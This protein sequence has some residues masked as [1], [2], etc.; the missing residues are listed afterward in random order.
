MNKKIKL[1]SVI[2]SLVLISGINIKSFSAMDTTLYCK[3]GEG[4]PYGIDLSGPVKNLKDTINKKIDVLKE[5]KKRNI[6]AVQRFNQTI[7]DTAD[8]ANGWQSFL[9][10]AMEEGAKSAA[11]SLDKFDS[12]E[13][14][15]NIAGLN[16]FTKMKEK[17]QKKMDE[18]KKKLM[19][20]MYSKMD[21][22]NS[23]IDEA[24]SGLDD[25]V[26][27]ANK[28]LTGLQG[29]LDSNQLDVSGLDKDGSSIEFPSFGMK[30][31]RPPVDLCNL[32]LSLKDLFQL[33]KVKKQ[34]LVSLAKEDDQ[35]KQKRINFLASIY[36]DQ[37]GEVANSYNKAKANE[38]TVTHS[39]GSTSDNYI[40]N[41]NGIHLGNTNSGSNNNS[42]DTNITVSAINTSNSDTSTN[43]SD[44][45]T[46]N[47]NDSNDSNS[48]DKQFLTGS[49]SE[50]DA[51]LSGVCD[52]L[53]DLMNKKAEMEQALKDLMKQTM[54]NVLMQALTQ[55]TSLDALVEAQK[56][57]QC[58]V[59][60]SV[61][62][63]SDMDALSK[64]GKATEECFSKTEDTSLKIGTE[65]GGGAKMAS[66]PL[67]FI[68][69]PIPFAQM[70]MTANT[71]TNALSEIGTTLA[72]A[73]SCL[74]EGYGVGWSSAYKSCM[75]STGNTNNALADFKFDLNFKFLDNF[76]DF[77]KM[78]C[79]MD[80]KMG[81]DF[82]ILGNLKEIADDNINTYKDMYKDVKKMGVKYQEKEKEKF[83]TVNSSFEK[84]VVFYN[85]YLKHKWGN[86]GNDY[87]TTSLHSQI[88]KKMYGKD[89][90][91]DFINFVLINDSDSI[92][93][94]IKNN[95]AQKDLIK[96]IDFNEFDNIYLINTLDI[97]AS[98]LNSFKLSKENKD[99]DTVKWEY[100]KDLMNEC[101][102]YIENIKNKNTLELFQNDNESTFFDSQL[103]QKDLYITNLK[104]EQKTDKIS[105]TVYKELLKFYG[106]KGI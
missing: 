32:D 37:Y 53:N 65:A 103:L 20:D 49:S 29:F 69:I 60:A 94:Y 9:K 70:S 13:G 75:D 82:S 91:D 25:A 26:A 27:N 18:E 101:S 78:K 84:N 61:K 85:A 64:A 4:S 22:L 98:R 90:S 66:V 57:L 2:S 79:I 19:E 100:N 47:S 93:D 59:Q 89:I 45:G 73:A 71:D 48:D 63:V 6:E 17:I 16:P 51:T 41:G 83:K 102:M 72:T 52:G 77:K 106:I 3:F 39:S 62:S 23:K 80:K 105:N 81:E 42:G 33:C 50:V 1:I 88:I 56:K 14:S 12:P 44:T 15:L 31:K 34:Q 46:A 43:N 11:N 5:L 24:Q 104:E 74:A 28:S 67:A 36:P 96:S 38:K 95:P 54:K 21:S 55:I 35:K 87:D 10:D 7:S 58:M 76:K 86:F 68:V 92:V 40:N 8:S 30:T 97:C 99:F